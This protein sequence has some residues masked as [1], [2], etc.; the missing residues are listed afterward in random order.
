MKKKKILLVDDDPAIR[1]M[2]MPRMDGQ[3]FYKAVQPMLGD[4]KF[5]YYIGG[6]HSIQ[7]VEIFRWMA[8]QRIPWITKMCS[9]DELSEFVGALLQP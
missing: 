2:K 5:A 8:E 3:E 6:S 4:T 1:D 9:P 7:A